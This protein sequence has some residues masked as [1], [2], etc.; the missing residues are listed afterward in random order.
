MAT[1]VQIVVIIVL[2]S[3]LAIIYL[4]FS[5]IKKACLSL[6]VF[7]GACLCATYG[8][9]QEGAVPSHIVEVASH[10]PE[11]KKAMMARFNISEERMNREL[12]PKPVELRKPTTAELVT[13]MVS[14]MALLAILM[15]PFSL[16]MVRE[17]SDDDAKKAY[18]LAWTYNV[19]ACAFVLSLYYGLE[20]IILPWRKK[21]LEE[22][23]LF[24]ALS[25]KELA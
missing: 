11:A 23:R 14:S 22:G 8:N 3:N 5:K 20:L 9:G 2:V 25:K 13:G 19:L 4:P 24:S 17:S 6:V 15:T 1:S 16:A 7:F 18:N 12:N 21:M 10:G